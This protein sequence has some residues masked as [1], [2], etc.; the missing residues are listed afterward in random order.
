MCPTKV[1]MVPMLLVVAVGVPLRLSFDLKVPS[2][3]FYF[4]LEVRLCELG[5]LFL[6]AT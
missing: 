2:F 1:L 4:W 6:P 5:G 3:G